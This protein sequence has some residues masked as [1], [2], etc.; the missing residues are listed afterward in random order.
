[1]NESS[2]ILRVPIEEKY[3]P[4]IHAQIDLV[5]TA[6]RT[7]DKG[8]VDK[9]LPK[10]PAFASGELNL[11][12][13]LDSRKLNVT[14]KPTEE[15]LEP[16]AQTTVNIEV[17]DNS[18]EPVADAEVALVA[19]DEGVLALSNYSIKNPLEDFYTDI[20]GGVLDFHSRQNV[21]LGNP[22]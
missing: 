7:D 22:E 4:N 6:E 20:A 16:G 1:M 9:T 19:V 13:S 3:L 18:G 11:K 21:L 12:I 14:A 15:T 5:G 2:T 17:K 8:E 10:R